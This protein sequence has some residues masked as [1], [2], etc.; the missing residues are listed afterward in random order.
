[1]ILELIHRLWEMEK[2][3]VSKRNLSYVCHK[4]KSLNAAKANIQREISPK[5]FSG[6]TVIYSTDHGH[7]VVVMVQSRYPLGVHISL[8]TH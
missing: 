2:K 8:K 6:W 3:E 5:E 7:K 4:D 1:M